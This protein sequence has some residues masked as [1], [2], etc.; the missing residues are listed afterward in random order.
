MVFLAEGMSEEAWLAVLD[1]DETADDMR[2][3]ML[4]WDSIAPACWPANDR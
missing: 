2:G 1:L 4:Y 3:K